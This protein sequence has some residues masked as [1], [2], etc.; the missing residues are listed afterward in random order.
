MKISYLLKMCRRISRRN[1]ERRNA[2]QVRK[3]TEKVDP[4]LLREKVLKERDEMYCKV[5]EHSSSYIIQYIEE[6]KTS[7]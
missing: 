3:E 4:K 7:G 5:L 2:I 1:E 6:T